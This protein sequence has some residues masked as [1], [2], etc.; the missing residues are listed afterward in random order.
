MSVITVWTDMLCAWSY[1]AVARLHRAR[2]RLAVDVAL[3]V[4]AWPAELTGGQSAGEAQLRN[5]AAA[6]AQ[7]EPTL[8]SSYDGARWP[9]TSVPA[10]EAQKWAYSLGPEIGEGFDLALRRALFLHSRDLSNATD[11]LAVAAAEGLD[12]EHLARALGSGQFRSAV[13]ADVAAGQEAGVEGTAQV[14]LPD[15]ASHLN[16][17][18]THQVVRGIP[19]VEADHPGVYDDLVRAVL[20]AA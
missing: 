5:Q 19:I 10:F 12:A 18:M 8:F 2:Q 13:T 7:R 1:V 4:R 6:L 3:D 17:G 16:P 15:G 20:N 14:D 11:L 9:A